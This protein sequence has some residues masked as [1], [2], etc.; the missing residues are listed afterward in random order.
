MSRI[1]HEPDPEEPAWARCQS[2]DGFWCRIHREHAESCP[3]PPVEDWRISPYEAG[4]QVC[5]PV[6]PL[7]LT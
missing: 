5:A 6:V 4:S 3:C 1:R 2:C 7:R